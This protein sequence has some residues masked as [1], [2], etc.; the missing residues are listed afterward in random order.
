MRTEKKKKSG[1]I[2]EVEFGLFI[3]FSIVI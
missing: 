1:K 3:E 2:S